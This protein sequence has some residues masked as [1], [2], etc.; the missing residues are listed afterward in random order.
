M[1]GRGK[2]EQCEGVGGGRRRRDKGRRITII[3]GEKSGE[4]RRK[5]EDLGDNPRRFKVAPNLHWLT[6]T[7]IRIGPKQERKNESK[8]KTR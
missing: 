3:R 5:E 4:G 2:E 1:P 8:I 7:E 6:Q